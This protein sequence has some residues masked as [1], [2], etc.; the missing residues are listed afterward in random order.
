MILVLLGLV[1]STLQ[2]SASSDY[3]TERQIMETVYRAG[4]ENLKTVGKSENLKT[5][6]KFTFVQP[7]YSLLEHDSGH[8]SYDKAIRAQIDDSEPLGLV[9]L[10]LCC[11]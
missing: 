5:V 9:C 2:V 6:G 3:L 4:L 10:V 1:S 7:L 8:G 11:C